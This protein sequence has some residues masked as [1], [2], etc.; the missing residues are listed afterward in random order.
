MRRATRQNAR[1]VCQ[2]AAGRAQPSLQQLLGRFL[3]M[4][5]SNHGARSARDQGIALP[6]AIVAGLVL[7]VGVAALSS[8]T[9]QGFIS[10]LF[11][12]VNREARDV[13][14]SAIAEFGVTMNRE[15]NR[16]LL[17]AGD[18][19]DWTDPKHRNICTASVKQADGTWSSVPSDLEEARG[20]S[21]ETTADRFVLQEPG[22]PEADSWIDLMPGDESRQF[23]VTQIEYF[24]ERDNLDSSG[25]VI[26]RDRVPY[27]FDTESTSFPG[28][29]VRD[30]AL[31]G[32][33]RTLL[34]V[35]VVGK[36]AR[37]GQESFARVAREF[38]VVPKCCKRS[39]GNNIGAIPWGRDNSPCP[40]GKDRGVGN[41]VIGSLDGGSPGS[42]KNELDIRDENNEL[43][44]QA[45]CWAGNDPDKPS[46]LDGD[47][48]QDCLDGDQKLGK[49]TKNKSAVSFLP[50][51]F[52]LKL[53]NPRFATG[54]YL[55]STPDSTDFPSFG[56]WY[57]DG[58]SW[59]MRRFV[60]EEM[61][62]PLPE[63]WISFNSSSS[64]VA[65]AFSSCSS[66][67]INSCKAI[68]GISGTPGIAP[69]FS[70]VGIPIESRTYSADTRI[71]VDPDTLFVMQRVGTNAA[72]RMNNCVVSKDPLAPY[73]VA[74]CHFS[75]INAGNNTVRIDT[76]Y[77][78][79]NFHF[80]DDAITGDYM[81]GNGNTTYRRVHCSRS[82]Y[83]KDT[84]NDA[85]DW[86]EFQVKCESSG[87]PNCASKDPSYDQ[88]E[89]FNAFATGA[90]R[91]DLK[92]TSSTV[93]MNVYAPLARVILRGGGNADPNF[94]GR[95][96]T[97]IIELNG[98]VKLRVPNSQPGFCTT[99]ICPPPSRVPL[100][101]VVA[102][103][104]SHASGF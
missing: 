78:V 27:S 58:T 56:V 68:S 60:D 50:Q 76:S 49:A 102:R 22:T 63:E 48:N 18:D 33:S 100:F 62:T 4:S 90:G 41:G 85:V 15:E 73:A 35:T 64:F 32:G 66:V 74:D 2:Q 44:T 42:S 95:I 11:Q 38:E 17:V 96:W 57:L 70:P 94:M 53:P 13:A 61:A 12:G 23:R 37:N 39:F 51:P 30:S 87:D 6:I 101:D 103:S 97:N 29:T 89:L 14:E 59:K 79:I 3:L 26:S 7:L 36:V 77:A 19:A 10:G 47:P 67:N 72:T 16:F 88:S 71:Y 45:I 98:N 20:D 21:A 99:T 1:R 43:I 25:N 54:G 93:G 91:F 24:F 80:R 28:K 31:E 82:G 55:S 52:S 9:S 69:G 83:N 84:C 65:P 104:F 34:R 46:D 40:V 81:G 86:T 75:Q 5:R 92:G 8:R